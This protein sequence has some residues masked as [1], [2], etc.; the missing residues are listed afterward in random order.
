M[1]PPD[2]P[3]HPPDVLQILKDARHLDTVIVPAPN[4]WRLIRDRSM[5]LVRGRD[6]T[7]RHALIVLHDHAVTKLQAKSST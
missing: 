2:H 7:T 5:R 1:I 3:W 4:A 6:A